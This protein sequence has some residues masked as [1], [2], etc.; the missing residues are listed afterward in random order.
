MI[1]RLAFVTGI[2]GTLAVFLV[3]VVGGATFPNF[4]H[5]SQFI[6]E[7]GADGAPHA[8][9]INLAGF[10]PAGLLLSAFAFFA[11]RLLPRSRATTLGLLGLVL[12]ALGYIAAA[13]F[14][15]EPGC[16]S[17][18]PSLSQTMHN[19]LGLA[20]YFT[21]PLSLCALGWG[22]RRWPKAGH[23]SVLG[24]IGGGLVLLSLLFFSPEFRYVG[25]VQRVLEGSVLSWVVVCAL[26]IKRSSSGQA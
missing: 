23:L 6:S 2:L 17:A 9:I 11:W 10:L 8:S 18:Q 21:A 16:R 3:T 26:Y 22:A 24:F 20:G 14:P 25:I 4:S 5:S 1:S 19:L 7:L 12:F 13:F 15:C